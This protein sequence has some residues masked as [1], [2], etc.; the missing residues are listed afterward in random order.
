MLQLGRSLVCSA[1]GTAVQVHCVEGTANQV[2]CVPAS[3][4][5]LIADSE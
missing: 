4:A 2:Y 3:V 5:L 1:G